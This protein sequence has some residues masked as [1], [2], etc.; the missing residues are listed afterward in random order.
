MSSTISG[1]LLVIPHIFHVAILSVVFARSPAAFSGRFP[2]LSVRFPL[3]LF[4]CT[5]LEQDCYDQLS[6]IINEVKDTDE[7]FVMGDLNGRV[8]ERT[9]LWEQYLGPFSDD[10]RECNSNGKMILELCAEHQLFIANTFYKHDLSKI[11]TRYCWNSTKLEDATQI[12]FI[13]PRQSMRRSIRDAKVLPN[14]TADTDHK[15]VVILIKRKTNKQ[16]N[17]KVVETINLTKLKEADKR[18]KLREEIV[19]K[20]E[21]I[22]NKIYSGIIEAWEDFKQIFQAALKKVC[23]MRKQGGVPKKKTKWWNED[24]KQAKQAKK[25]AFID[26]KKSDTDEDY[27]IYRLARRDSKRAVK[28]SKDEAWREY[29][30]ELT[31]TS[32]TSPR[33]FYKSVKAMR[34]REESFIPTEVI[35]DSS[36]VLLYEEHEIKV[37][38]A[39]YFQQLL[40]PNTGEHS[41]QQFQPNFQQDHEPSILEQETRRAINKSKNNKSPGIDEIPAE[42]VKICGEIGIK[43]LTKL[44]NLAWS[45]RRVPDDWQWAIIVAIW[46]KKGS[47]RDCKTYRG[48]SLLSHV[49]K[50]YARIIESRIRY[51]VEPQLSKSQFGFR[52][53]RGCTDAVFAL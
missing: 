42:A 12:D 21:E 41:I 3:L 53:G 40:N 15:P 11:K 30:E 39:E 28:K 23:G 17:S 4:S 50:M 13:L 25:K 47:K 10:T 49:G 43:W 29:G 44:F 22:E 32:K 8:G 51:I 31:K 16:Q 14:T 5:I 52:K 26:W 2:S 46:K 34:L 20:Y 19:T 33:D 18:E 27:V 38:W 35:M 1:S 6:E 7:L 37:R 45:E 24:V 48:I 9:A 36:G